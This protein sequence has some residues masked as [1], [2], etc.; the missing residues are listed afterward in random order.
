MRIK[1]NLFFFII[2]VLPFT[3]L[4][5]TGCNNSQREANLAEKEQQLQDNPRNFTEDDFDI[6][7]LSEAFE[8][9]T[10]WFDTE[11]NPTRSSKINSLL[12]FDDEQVQYYNT[13][14]N[15][16]TIEDVLT[17]SETELIQQ[18]QN[19]SNE[20]YQKLESSVTATPINITEELK[21]EYDYL[22][23]DEYFFEE[24]EMAIHEYQLPHPE[25]LDWI[26]EDIYLEIEDDK[27]ALLNHYH[28]D[29]T[30]DS[31][32]QQSEKID[33]EIQEALYTLTDYTEP[34]LFFEEYERLLFL[35]FNFE[36]GHM[37]DNPSIF[38]EAYESTLQQLNT[39]G[40]FENTDQSALQH[41][42]DFIPNP[43]SWQTENKEFTFDSATNSEKI[44]DTTFL[45][46][47]HQK[48]SL[49]T[50]VENMFVQFQLD[51]P[52]TN[53]KNVTIEGK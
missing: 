52:D 9:Y 23:E 29:I 15:D 41:P 12:V 19:F 46:F 1:T 32:G 2:I 42:Q 49:I 21:L 38:D 33:F 48:G 50:A 13:S 28:L 4:I 34:R 26:T 31:Y 18:A 24:F 37:I 36:Y 22:K 53:R 43:I 25:D 8:K 44:F 30:L 7:T 20:K 27:P 14:G 51:G 3:L 35:L 6:Y 17:M 39:V 11:Q 10:I 45:G 16:F 40:T 5:L 47:N